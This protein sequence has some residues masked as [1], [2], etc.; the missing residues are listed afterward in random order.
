VEVQLCHGGVWFDDCSSG[1]TEGFADGLPCVP[2]ISFDP[3]TGVSSLCGCADSTLD[4]QFAVDMVGCDGAWTTPG[5]GSTGA[6]ALCA[7]GWHVCTSVAEVSALGLSGCPEMPPNTFY[8]TRQSGQTG[9]CN[10]TDDND[11]W[12]C[13]SAGQSNSCGPLN[14]MFGIDFNT[15]HSLSEWHMGDLWH[16]ASTVTKATTGQG[17]VMC[18]KDPNEDSN[19]INSLRNEALAVKPGMGSI[20]VGTAAMLL[21]VAMNKV[22]RVLRN[23]APPQMM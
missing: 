4:H 21:G 19:M 1:Y 2:E 20:L 12:G 6:E 10:P 22:V 17:G 7:A 8:S 18:C 13:G 23:Q 15:D 5:I 3:T 9:T 11:V 14:R 16:E